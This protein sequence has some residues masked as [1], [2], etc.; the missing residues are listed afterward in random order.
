MN[1]WIIRVAV[2]ALWTFGI[3]PVAAAAGDIPR[4]SL[5]Q[6][7]QPLTDWTAFRP[8][9]NVSDTR[10]TLVRDG[11]RT[12]LRADA[13]ASM[14]GLAF[15]LRVDVRKFP[16]LRWSWK[17]A[18]PV[19][20]G[21]MTTREGDDYAARLYVLFDYPIDKLPLATR[22]RLRLARAMYG[23]N[24]PSAAL[25][26][27]W[28]NRQPI[29][30]IQPNTYAER[31]RM[32]VVESGSRHAGQWRTETRDLAADFQA[33]FGDQEVP[34]LIGIALATDTDNTGETAI[35]WYGDIELLPAAPPEKP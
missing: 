29:G 14:S 16:V 12:V 19:K 5:M 26:Y 8:A 9:A 22:A 1:R 15:P 30:T 34:P 10:Y 27:V 20:S 35:A 7:G 31:A 17:I 13:A 18:A 32:I 25:N 6:P 28:D 23:E 11:A 4:F 3:V 2:G 24:V 21:N 33:A